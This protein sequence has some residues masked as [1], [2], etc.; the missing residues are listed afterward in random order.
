MGA[1][2]KLKIK[3]S[4]EDNSVD[5]YIYGAIVTD[6]D[7]EKGVS[8]I[9]FR[10]ALKE[11]GEVNTI[12]LHIN[13]PG[14]NVFEGI[15]IYNMLKQNKATINVYIDGLAASIASVVAM[16]GDTIF[17]PSN[18]KLMIHNPWVAG[19]A[20]NA[21]DLRKEADDL[22]KITQ[23][24][25]Q[26]YLDKTKGKLDEAKLKEIM[27]DETWLSAQEALDYGFVDEIL[28]ANKVAACV[29]KSIMKHY[30]NV[31]KQLAKQ[32]EDVNF[33]SNLKKQ[34]EAQLKQ[35]NS[36]LENYRGGITHEFLPN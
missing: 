30:V 12:N 16:S 17:M 19:V 1:T 8:A 20:G 34:A 6:D 4:V 3:Q 14:G 23:S 10:D 24:S 33:R 7:D 15:A 9:D 32:K 5:M 31:P 13:S 18:A 26:I 22:D 21:S 36:E 25:V 35:I 27:D 29:D 2:Q 11:L 28:E